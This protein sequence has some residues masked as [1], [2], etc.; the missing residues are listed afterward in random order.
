M[1]LTSVGVHCLVFR[2][3]ISGGNMSYFDDDTPAR[4][5]VTMA[6]LTTA[7]KRPLPVKKNVS[8]LVSPLTASNPDCRVLDVHRRSA[9]FEPVGLR[10]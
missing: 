5:V 9:M 10:T 7:V 2:G 6:P 1:R 8:M 3:Q 4:R